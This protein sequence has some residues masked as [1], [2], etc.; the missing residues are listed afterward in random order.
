MRVTAVRRGAGP[1]A[2]DPAPDVD[3][4]AA[5]PAGRAGAGRARRLTRQRVGPRAAQRVDVPRDS[6]AVPRHIDSLGGF[7]GVVDPVAAR[8]LVLMHENVRA[9]VDVDLAGRRGRCLAIGPRGSVRPGGGPST[10]AVPR[11]DPDAACR[12]VAH[13]Q[14]GDG[15]RGRPGGRLQLGRGVQPGLQ[16]LDRAGSVPVAEVSLGR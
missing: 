9:A 15:L 3:R 11:A 1:P 5:R 13:E 12:G 7:A 2:A 8:A 10:D 6:P 4:A 14:C 16:A